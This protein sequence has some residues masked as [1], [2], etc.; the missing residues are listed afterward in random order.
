GVGDS[1]GAHEQVERGIGGVGPRVDRNVAL[2]QHRHPGHAVRVEMVQVDVQQR[3]L[4]RVHAAAQRRLD[5][6]NVVETLGSVQIDDQVHAGA[7]HAVANG[8]V[9]F[10][11]LGGGSLD[12]ANVSAVLSGTPSSCPA[13]PRSH[14]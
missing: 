12:H 3:R 2:G 4:C 8:E 9:A 13:L 14:N 1:L 5:Q 10:A 7:A 11:P 6:I